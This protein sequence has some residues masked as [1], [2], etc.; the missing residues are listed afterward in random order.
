M[1]FAT[2]RFASQGYHATSVAEIV[3]GVG[4]GKGVFY[5]YFSSKEELFTA[6]L[7]DAQLDL[8]R[9]QRRAIAT[10]DDPL[11]RI[12]RG[13]AASMRWTANH[14]ELFRLM[15]F[16][17][18]EDR[19]AGLVRKGRE[20]AVSDAL[21]HV[22]DAI[23]EGQ[24]PDSNPLLVTCALYGVVNELN[25]TFVRAGEAPADDVVE[26]AVQFCVGG[27][28]GAARTTAS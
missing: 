15:Q 19:F 11:D 6:V 2:Q 13:I 25:R 27:L 28:L 4:V 1:H 10:A 22:K 14:P 24:I 18:T 9:Y 7:S 23:A 21:R 20:V 16:A 26:A 17:V 12:A 3:R 5:W 8:R